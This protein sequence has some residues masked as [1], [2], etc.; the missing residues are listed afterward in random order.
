MKIKTLAVLAAA[1]SLSATAV[2][3]AHVWEDPSGWWDN[4]FY[5]ARD[6]APKF[7]AQ[8]ISLDLFG[9]YIAGQRGIDEL[10]DTDITHG[11]WG[12]GVGLNYFFTR[13]LGLSV[14]MNIPDNDG[15]FIDSVSGSL[16]ARMPWEAAGLAPYLFGGGGRVTEPSYQWELHAGVGLEWRFNP[17]TGIFVDGRYVWADDAYEFDNGKWDGDHLLFRAGLRLVF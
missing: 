6:N 1:L 16:V 5:V 4:H 3:A 7:S 11:K 2:N 13:E 17:L 12:G 8:E 14:D 10:F 15:N 9:S